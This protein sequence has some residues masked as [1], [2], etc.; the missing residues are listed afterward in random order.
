MEKNREKRI[1]KDIQDSFRGLG[2]FIDDKEI[3]DWY[4][5]LIYCMIDSETKSLNKELA[6]YERKIKRK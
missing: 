1:K 4:L 3:L 5:D 6:Q 2:E